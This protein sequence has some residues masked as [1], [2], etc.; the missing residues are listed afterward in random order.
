MVLGMVLVW[1][2]PVLLVVLV[3][4]YFA[5]DRKGK[6]EPTALE[7]LEARYAHGEIDQDEYL[8]RR[9]DLTG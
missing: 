6:R 5:R 8:K 2:L 9:A 7:I 1:G 3:V 4:R